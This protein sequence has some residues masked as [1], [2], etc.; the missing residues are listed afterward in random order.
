M[1]NV[2]LLN[3]SSCMQSQCTQSLCQPGECSPSVLPVDEVGT[4]LQPGVF[5]RMAG[6]VPASHIFF[7]SGLW[8]L[9]N[10]KNGFT[11]HE[12]VL[13]EEV[14]KF[15]NATPD[16]QVHWKMTT[17]SKHRNAPEF[18]FVRS[19][20]KSGAFDSWYDTWSLTAKVVNQ[21]PQLLWDPSHF[22]AKVYRGLNQALIAYLWSVYQDS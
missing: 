4:I 3:L 2:S 20:V 22:D 12:K 10:G 14:F 7:N 11:V 8:Y 19:L 18:D 5:S 17:S 1:H 13:V 9:V 21:Y 16:V 6:S 15:R